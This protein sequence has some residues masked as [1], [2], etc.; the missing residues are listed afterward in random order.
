MVRSPLHGVVDLPGWWLWRRLSGFLVHFSFGIE[1]NG[2]IFGV[3]VGFIV[4]VHAV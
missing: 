4:V 1:V 2:A 3:M